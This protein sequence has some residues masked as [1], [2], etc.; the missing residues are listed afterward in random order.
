MGNNTNIYIPTD[1]K[2]SYSDDSLYNIIYWGV[3]FSFGELIHKY[4]KSEIIKPE[5]QR[6]Y[7]WTI[8]EASRFID[9]VLLGLPIPGI[10]L[11]KREDERLLII[12]G[13]Q[14]IMTMHDFIQ[15][16]FSDTKKPF[17]LSNNKQ[18][19]EKWRKKSYADLTDHEKRKIDNTMIHAVV[20]MQKYPKN[21]TGMYQIFER[22]NTTGK[23]LKPQ[24]IR[25]C[26]SYGS[27]N[28]LLISMN[29][30]KNWRK[31]LDQPIPDSRMSDI[32]LILRFFTILEIYNN[33]INKKQIILNKELNEF[34]EVHKNLSDND[35][36]SY[37]SM[38]IE[39]ID[40][41]LKYIGKNAFN[42]I[43]QNDIYVKQIYPTIYDAVMIATFYFIR[44]RNE[45]NIND[46]NEKHVQLLKDEE[47]KLYVSTHTTKIEHIYGRINLAKK[48]LYGI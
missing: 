41:I 46:I 47:F 7:V 6:K 25:N 28:N 44:S 30:N 18:I 42:N 43:N 36:I 31:L 48:I 35:V 32:E 22:I 11:S 39:T 34:M 3:D 40:F 10:F 26:V 24:E 23:V 17:V 14:R 4:N 8:K 33:A 27:F 29:E 16:Y 37:R 20:F 1:E 15:G 2:E 9:S 45:I 12:D 13:Y 38:F 21:D 19:N 5:L